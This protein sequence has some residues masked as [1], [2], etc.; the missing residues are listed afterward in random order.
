MNLPNLLTVSRIVF[1]IPILLCLSTSNLGWNMVAALFFFGA[2][3]TDL[4]DG[5]IAR[6]RGEVTTLGKLL[7]PL[8]DKILLLSAVVP[9]VSLDRIPAWLAVVILAREFAV[10]GL[11]GMVALKGV[12]MGAGSKGKVK[13]AI[14]TLALFLLMVHMQVLGMLVLLLGLSVALYSAYEYFAGH[15]EMFARGG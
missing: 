8:A 9:L 5:F 3:F 6:S 12:S 15:R 13:T 4:A 1:V 7:D 2:S 10:T 11:R 14:Y